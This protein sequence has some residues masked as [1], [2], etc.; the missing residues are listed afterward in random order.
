[1]EWLHSYFPFKMSFLSSTTFCNTTLN[2]LVF[3]LLDKL[4]Y[5]IAC[6]YLDF[7]S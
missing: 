1:L 6:H 3:E 7:P 2:A 4:G 5:A